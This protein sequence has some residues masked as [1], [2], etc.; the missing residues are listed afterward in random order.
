MESSDLLIV[1]C[2]YGCFFQ[3]SCNQDVLR[4]ASESFVVEAA[5]RHVPVFAFDHD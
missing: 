4:A 5:Q 2:N 3:V 1:L